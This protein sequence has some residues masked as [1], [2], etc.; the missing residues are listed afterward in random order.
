MAVKGQRVVV[1]GGGIVGA[2]VAW[3]LYQSGINV[4]VLEK[5]THP[6]SGVTA[7]SYGWVGTSSALP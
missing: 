6:A 3:H 7:H 5:Y 2:S 1:V 4:T